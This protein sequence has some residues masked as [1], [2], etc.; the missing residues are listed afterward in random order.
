MLVAL[1]SHNMNVYAKVVSDRA[2]EFGQG[3]NKSLSI[4]FTVQH[5]RK[6]YEL[7]ATARLKY[8]P[9]DGLG[10]YHLEVIG[11]DGNTA[12]SLRQDKRPE[13]LAQK[14]KQQKGKQQC[15]CGVAQPQS[16][17]ICIVK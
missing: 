11:P 7:F 8:D 10:A 4:D 6:V 3:G 5:G 9:Q 2:K 17:H 12:F 13:T 15:Y 16:D 1:L 14:G